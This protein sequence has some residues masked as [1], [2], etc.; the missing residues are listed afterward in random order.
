ML[1]AQAGLTQEVAAERIGITQESLSQLERNR[2]QPYMPTLVKL[3]E[4]YGVPIEELLAEQEEP[5]LPKAELPARGAEWYPDG[6]IEV[7]KG[8]LTVQLFPILRRVLRRVESG[9]LSAEEALRE[10]QGSGR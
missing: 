9:E 8:P 2:R 4:G 5:A 7:L 1:R 10:L 3:A 6:G